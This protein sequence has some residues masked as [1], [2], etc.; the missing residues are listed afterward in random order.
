MHLISSS[1]ENFSLIP[2]PTE[3]L[4]LSPL[5]HSLLSGSARPQSWMLVGMGFCRPGG[6]VR[7]GAL[8][9]ANRID[10]ETYPYIQGKRPAREEFGIITK[11]HLPDNRKTNL[12]QLTEKGLALTPIIVELSIWG[13]ENVRELNRTMKESP[14]I[15]I[16]K[17]NKAAF[18]R[19]IQENY[20]SKTGFDNRNHKIN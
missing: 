9:P 12:Y 11:S 19:M 13:D 8:P 10:I 3:I 1:C 7:H 15:E 18:I 5:H 2:D 20:K 14:D 4:R 17:T 6:V 16:M